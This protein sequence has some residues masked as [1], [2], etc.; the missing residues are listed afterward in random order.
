MIKLHQRP[1]DPP[2]I[3]H[4]LPKQSDDR[5]DQ[6]LGLPQRQ[7]KH[8]AHLRAVLIARAE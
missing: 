7:A 6:P 3:L 1:R 2:R 4:A 8:Q 5:A